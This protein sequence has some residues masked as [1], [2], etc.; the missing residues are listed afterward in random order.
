MRPRSMLFSVLVVCGTMMGAAAVWGQDKGKPEEAKAQPDSA[1]AQAMMQRMME[2]A[3]P[4]PQHKHLEKMAGKWA[5]STRMWSNGPT[6]P[7]TESQG[8]SEMKMIFGGRYLLEEVKGDFNGMP[9]E[10]MEIEGYD[11][12]KKEHFIFWIDNMGTM[13]LIGTGSADSTGKV[14]TYQSIYDDPATGEKNKKMKQVVRVVSDDELAYE[15]YD[16]QQGK[17]IK[18]ME[19]SYKRVK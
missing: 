6:A 18:T 9:F 12:S 1:Q 11:N 2:M 15:M 8:T 14:L 19:M 5:V 13:M 16:V 3:T 17:E 10:G 4:G 7:P